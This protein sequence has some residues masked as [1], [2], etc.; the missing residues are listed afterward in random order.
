MKTESILPE[1]SKEGYCPKS[2]ILPMKMRMTSQ[3]AEEFFTY[4]ANLTTKQMK[5]RK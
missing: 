4:S 3:T 2:A 1:S 5:I